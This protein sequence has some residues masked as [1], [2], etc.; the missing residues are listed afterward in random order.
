ARHYADK[1]GEANDLYLRG[2]PGVAEALALF[3]REAENIRHRQ[4]WAAR[5]FLADPDDSL[6]A[7][8]CADFP[9]IGIHVV[10]MRLRATEWVGWLE[11]SLRACG[12]L[13]S[14]SLEASAL[15]LLG[16]A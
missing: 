14:R 7:R 6:A 15:N 3:D 5:A 9:L 13:G 8:T 11:T 4:A 2:G 16:F 10:E 12:R 1:L